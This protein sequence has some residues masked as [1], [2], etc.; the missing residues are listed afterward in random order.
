MSDIR[1][2]HP[3]VFSRIADFLV[4]GATFSVSCLLFSVVSVSTF[5]FQALTYSTL[6]LVC[7]QLCKHA[8]VSYNGSIGEASRQI[9]GNG[10]GIL[11]GT[12]IMLVFEN[13]VSDSSGIFVVVIFS[14]VMAFFIL[15]TL[16]PMLHK[17]PIVHKK[18]APF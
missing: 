2:S 18:P 12:C 10:A 16:S 3:K 1:N 15:G 4:L 8:I 7:V 13:L 11:I 17:M 9:L 6:L 14:S 5:F